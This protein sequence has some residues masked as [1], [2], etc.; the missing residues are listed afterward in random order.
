MASIKTKGAVVGPQTS[1]RMSF[2]ITVTVLSL[3][4]MLVVGQLYTFFLFVG[5]GL[6]PQL[7][8]ALAG[9][10]FPAVSLAAAAILGAGALLALG[11]TVRSRSARQL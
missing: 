3:A 1:A 2:L 11:S 4:G 5:A 7:A 6:G 8:T 9:F 10:G